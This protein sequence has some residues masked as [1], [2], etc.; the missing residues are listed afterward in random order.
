[1]GIR[2]GFS[3]FG[4]FVLANDWALIVVVTIAIMVAIQ[5]AGE[6]A[7]SLARKLKYSVSTLLALLVAFIIIALTVRLFNWIT[8]SKPDGLVP[9]LTNNG[10]D[11]TSAVDMSGTRDNQRST[12]SS[13]DAYHSLYE[14]DE[15]GYNTKGGSRK[16]SRPEKRPRRRNQARP[17]ARSRDKKQKQKQNNK[18][19]ESNKEISKPGKRRDQR[20]QEPVRKPP[21]PAV[22]TKP[23]SS[24][25]SPSSPS[26]PSAKQR[27]VES[28]G[29]PPPKTAGVSHQPPLSTAIAAYA[30]TGSGIRGTI[31]SILGLAVEGFDSVVDLA[32]SVVKKRDNVGSSASVSASGRRK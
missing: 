7:L 29:K 24:S 31:N 14:Q 4:D 10:R 9:V 12:A 3:E 17:T 16:R 1:M 32:K 27:R 15:F 5:Y 30:P 26:P 11:T 20:I 21:R 25:S 22:N 6:W 23:S 28:V 18:K 8:Q 19:K 13:S 2:T